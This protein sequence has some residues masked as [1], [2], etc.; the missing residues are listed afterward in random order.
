MPQ[1]NELQIPVITTRD[2]REMLDVLAAM[3]NPPALMVYGAPGIGKTSI[4][5]DFSDPQKY[6]L[7]VK[8]LSR[9]DATDWSGI[10]KQGENQK[11]TEFLP[12]SIF[13]PAEAGKRIVLFFDELNTATPQVLNAALDVILEKK[14]EGENAKLPQNTIILAAGNLGEE[15][16]TMV[17]KLS[18]A[19]KTRM[20]QVRMKAE[21]KQWVEWAKSKSLHPSVIR[22][23]EQNPRYLL[24]LAGF[25]EEL[26]QIATPRGWERVSHLVTLLEKKN[27]A[28]LAQMVKGT[29]G[30]KVGKQFLAF[31]QNPHQGEDNWKQKIGQAAAYYSGNVADKTDNILF[32][33]TEAVN[34]GLKNG[35]DGCYKQAE[36][37]A[38]YLRQYPIHKAESSLFSGLDLT[39][40]ENYLVQHDY[41]DVFDMIRGAR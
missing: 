4:L 21:P 8:H 20:I 24:D 39:D 31:L 25:R 10:P 3:E 13:K 18:S 30:K 5:L 35:Y 22:F 34:D 14:G 19:V 7:R 9:M 16:G 2:L 29:V 17:E 28:L 36:K 41:A 12:I 26:D 6:D 32:A 33:L 37:Y 15:D 11:F 38:T 27:S 1:E 23:I 40:L